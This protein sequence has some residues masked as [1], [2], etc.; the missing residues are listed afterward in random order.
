M[1]FGPVNPID[2]PFG[3]FVLN[4]T[5]PRKPLCSAA[6]GHIARGS[7]QLNRS[8][9]RCEVIRVSLRE[10]DCGKCNWCSV[11]NQTV[12]RKAVRPLDKY[13]WMAALH[14]ENGSF[15]CGGAII[16]STFIV[17]SA[18]CLIDLNVSAE[19][20]CEGSEISEDCFIPANMTEVSL[21][22]KKKFTRRIKV[23]KFIPHERFNQRR[24]WHDIALVQ[25]ESPIRCQ[26][27]VFPICLPTRNF[28]KI[29]KKLLVL[30]WKKH[31][32]DQSSKV[33]F[34]EF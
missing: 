7:G 29:G 28:H 30:G 31:W 23:K 8:K 12:E 21:L 13:P 18:H 33:S 11:S 27:R 1:P 9:D 25:L 24:L 2:S 15:I 32:A 4:S 34:T 10:H 6:F 19:D 22:G 5:H 16:S 17:T 20:R 26:E 14:H 3:Q